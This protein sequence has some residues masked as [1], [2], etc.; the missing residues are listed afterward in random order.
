MTSDELFG[1]GPPT[2]AAMVLGM[3]VLERLSALTAPLPWRAAVRH[4]WTNL[5]LALLTA[6]PSAAGLAL[7]LATSAWA[8]ARGVGLLNLVDWPFWA[9]LAVAVAGI[10][11]ADWLRHLA[12]HHVGWL[13]RL[14]RVH[15]MDPAC[16]ATTS[17]RA[18]P[19]EHAL[20]Y[21]WFALWVLL[22]GLG[23]LELAGRTLITSVLLSWHH[24]AFRVPLPLERL[25]SLVTPTP[26][27]HRQ[28]HSRDVRFTNSN[29]GTLLT[30]W[31][32]LFGTF[33]PATRWRD[34]QTGLDG[35][36]APERQSIWGAL[37]SIGQAPE[38][39]A[40]SP[41]PRKR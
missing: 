2:L 25:I 4:G 16:D 20:A 40:L 36:D 22:L 9:R 24:S 8:R 26:R 5:W 30:C 7:L 39:S 3:T 33:S 29:Y 6:V 21:P 19:L 38:P 18:H 17:V 13:W 41:E 15:H 10:D 32:R 31:D 12:H 27:T 35:F 14:H 34:E 1:L 23:P 28:H 11:L 37:T